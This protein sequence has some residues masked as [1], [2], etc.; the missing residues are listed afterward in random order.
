MIGTTVPAPDLGLGIDVGASKIQLGVIDA[1]GAVL[2]RA[3]LSPWHYS[4]MEDNL[5]NLM[6]RLDGLMGGYE[7]HRFHDIGVGLPGTVDSVTGVV[8]YTPN[9]R[10]FDLPLGPMLTERTGLGV[11][12]VQDTAAAAW[13]EYLYGAGQGLKNIAC[14]TIGSGVACGMV[15]GGELYGGARHTAGEIGHLRV[16]DE[17]L[18]C[19]CG[20]RGCLEAGGSG[21]GLVKIFERNAKALGVEPRRFQDWP[22]EHPD[23]QLD[24]QLYR[25]PEGQPKDRFN[26]GPNAH[27]IFEAAKRGDDLCLKSIAEMV[28]NLA[29]GLSV[30]ATTLA[31]DA[32]ILS[33]G[34]SRERELLIEPLMERTRAISYHTVVENVRLAPAALGADAPLVGAAA[35]Y[36][37]SE[38]GG[39][40]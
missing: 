15:I 34:L 6:D 5:A 17:S 1:E 24:Q 8:S 21:L 4:K 23:E 38:Y 25:Q 2:R 26:Q 10:W 12:L 39:A 40:R 30:V 22:E 27:A 13:G 29:L 7:R 14:I 3:H 33:G 9:L 36:L 11:H 37:S 35:L 19:G 20:G 32:L 16:A 28:E 18:V 31:P